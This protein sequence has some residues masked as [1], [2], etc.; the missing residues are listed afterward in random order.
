MIKTL[1]ICAALGF[2][3]ES[4]YAA[5]LNN[6]VVLDLTPTAEHPRSSEGSFA[7]LR[8]GDLIFCYSQFTGGASDFNSS[9][10][11]EV[12]SHDQGRTWS[13]PRALFELKGDAQEMSVSLLRLASGQLALFSVIK[14][15]T[16]ECRPYL[17]LSSDEGAHWSEPKALF[18][19]P[20]YFVLNNDRV[21]QTASGRII[22]PVGFHRTLPSSVTANWGLDLRGI[23]LWYYSDDDGATWTEAKDWW[24]L[25]VASAAGLQEPGLVELADGSLFSWARTDQGCQYEFR[26]TDGGIH[27]SAPQPGPVQSPNGPA[28]IKRVPGSSE[29]M[30]VF[31]DYSGQFPFFLTPNVYSGRSPLAAAFSADGGRTWA[32]GKLLEGDLTRD[33]AYI[34]LHFTDDA[35]LAAYWVADRATHRFDLRIRRLSL[36]WLRAPEDAATTR[37]RAALHAI[38]DEEQAWVKIH[39]AEALLAGGEGAGIREQFLRLMPQV[40]SLPYRVG[41]WRV[42]ANTSPTLAE[43]NVAVAAVEKI[44][45]NPASPDRSQ[46]IETLCKLRCALTGPI[47]NEVRRGADSGPV[48]LRPLCLWSLAL[49]GDRTALDRLCALLRSPDPTMRVDAAYALRWLGTTNPQALDELAGAAAVEPADTKAYPYLLSAAYALHA[50]PAQRAKWRA[51]LDRLL[52][53]GMSDARFEACQGLMPEVVLSD[54]PRYEAL[55]DSTDHDTQVGAAWTFFYAHARL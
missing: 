30:A 3:G 21:I 44:Y 12:V 4:A 43:R 46:A 26:S 28:S 54:L 36:D 20:G 39:A 24:T 52:E 8:S 2:G 35:A 15:G 55:L 32:H 49:S 53:N 50:G 47:L 48:L 17:R 37:G 19:A 33:F 10:V 7:T 34:A 18:S 22:V 5:A 13:Q 42:L 27:W 9:G 23:V 40:D 25:P 1:L 51:G 45:L 29:L 31:D 16:H 6:E 14:H 11:A 41:V 38:F